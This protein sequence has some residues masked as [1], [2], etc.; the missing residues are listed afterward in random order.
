M[1]SATAIAP[2]TSPSRRTMTTVRL[3]ASQ[4]ALRA[5]TDGSMATLHASSSKGAFS[6]LATYAVRAPERLPLEATNLLVA[7]VVQ[8][9]GYVGSTGTRRPHLHF[10]VRVGLDRESL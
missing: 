2:T 10:E 6:K 3:I 9:I 8:V 4:S 5:A 1:L 7:N